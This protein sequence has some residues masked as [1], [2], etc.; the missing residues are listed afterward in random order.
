MVGNVGYLY[1]TNCF[2]EMFQDRCGTNGPIVGGRGIQ[3]PEIIYSDAHGHLVI[4]EKSLHQALHTDEWD[5]IVFM[6]VQVVL[7]HSRNPWYIPL[8]ELFY[9]LRAGYF[10]TLAGTRDTHMPFLVGTCGTIDDVV[11]ALEDAMNIPQAREDVKCFA[12]E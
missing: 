8:L 5:W 7:E 2:P 10:T 1:V 6:P 4:R 12:R 9:Q 11:H 3:L